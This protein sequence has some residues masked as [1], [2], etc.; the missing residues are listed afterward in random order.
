MSELDDA[1]IQHIRYI[2][3]TE[4]RPFSYRDFRCFEVNDKEYGMEHGT[5][6]NKVSQLMRIGKVEQEYRSS[7]TFYSIK[8]VR[9]GKRKSNGVM[10]MPMMT[11]NHEEVAQCHCHCHHLPKENVVHDTIIT[12]STLPIYDLIEN[13][14]LD[15]T[16]LHDI[17]MRFEVPNIYTNLS[18]SMTAHSQEQQQLQLDSFSKDIS[19]PPWQI[20]D[21]NIKVIVHRTD[22]VSVIVGCSY[23]PIAT[24]VGGVIRLSNALTRVEERISHLVD[25]NGKVTP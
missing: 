1:M 17:H 23:A 24:D 12:S 8:D 9:F 16:A 13:L 6:R 20:K 19:L 14:P 3:L 10:K 15:K 21:L 18:S 22:T 25:D 4:R 5:F 2:V 11:P 7:L